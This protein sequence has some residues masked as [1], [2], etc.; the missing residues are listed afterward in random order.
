[1]DWDIFGSIKEIISTLAVI[2]S[3][4]FVG[5]QLRQQV[6]IARAAAERDLLMQLRDWVSLPSHNEECFNAIRR[7]LNYF[8]GA[9]DWSRQQFWDWATSALLI[10]ESVLYMKAE[11]FFH[12]G[13]YVRF[14]Q[15]VL[16]IIRTHG[17]GQWWAYM[18]NV[19]GTDVGEHIRERI[20][21][22]GDT[23]PPWD[24]LLPHFKGSK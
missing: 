13:S 19:I 5:Y 4:I 2:A 18:Y 15:L 6:Y 14:E 23:V 9:D 16:S 10:F 17:G 22:I 20:E 7:C 1:M 8:D 24:E 3:L 21:E 12:V 11:N